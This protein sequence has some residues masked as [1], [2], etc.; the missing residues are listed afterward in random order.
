MTLSN[1]ADCQIFKTEC[2]FAS[3]WDSRLA[4]RERPQAWQFLHLLAALQLHDRDFDAESNILNR[5]W[6]LAPLTSVVFTYRSDALQGH[7]HRANFL[8]QEMRQ[9]PFT[10]D[11]LGLALI[12]RV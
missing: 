11:S 7:I 4:R 1:Y 5:I 8:L 6:L 2:D 3:E 9:S 12:A 10:L